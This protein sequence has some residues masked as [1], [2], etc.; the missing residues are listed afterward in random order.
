MF[1]SDRIRLDP[2]LVKIGRIAV[3]MKLDAYLVGGTVRDLLTGK[4]GLDWDIVTEGD[5]EPLVRA[6]AKLVKGRVTSYPMFGT[7]SV[8]TRA[9]R[10][11]DFATARKETYARPGALP[12]VVFSGIEHDIFRRD[13]TI[14]ALA[15]NLNGGKTAGVV[16]LF[17]GRRDLNNRVLRVLHRKSF[18]DDPTRIFRLARFAARGFRVDKLTEKLAAASA[19]LVSRVSAERAAR[20]LML[21][22][23]EKDPYAA[24]K[25]LAGWKVTDS[26]IPGVEISSRLSGLSK[27]R[28]PES[29]LALLFSQV[30]KKSRQK[31]Y[32]ALRF[33]NKLRN[34]VEKLLEPDKKKPALN[35]N[36][37]IKMGYAQ[38]PRFKVILNALAESGIVSRPA[39]KRFVFDN[40]PQKI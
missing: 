30:T 38:G 6:A 15:A 37:L 21:V 9:G 12:Q 39:A 18:R 25:T 22:M 3:A 13:F 8:E 4:K 27:I 10:R 31:Y 24:L 5:P 19:G 16:D 20:E 23:E 33:S 14:N 34:R 26:L 29:R 35:G 36:D 7:Y 2:V 32:S 1:K 28:A 17:G 40:F 11:I